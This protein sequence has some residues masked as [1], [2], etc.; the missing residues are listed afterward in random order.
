[1][2]NRPNII[3]IMSDDHAS[4]AI[5]AYTKND[6][7]RPV[8][9]ETPNIDRI[10]REG[11]RFNNCFCTNSICT[12]SRAVILTGKYSHHPLNGVKTFLPM[13]NSLP[14]VAKDLQK[15]GY[16]TAMIGKWHLGIGPKHCPTGFDY[17]K[18][19][20]GQGEYF[21]PLFIEKDIHVPG[22][23]K[24]REKGYVTDLITDYTIDWIKTRDVTKPFFIM[25]HHKAPHRPWVPDE[26][27]KHLYEDIEIP[28]PETFDDD[29]STSAARKNAR[30]RIDDDFNSGDVKVLPPM[31]TG[32]YER[33]RK[34]DESELSNYMLEPYD[35][36]NEDWVGEPVRFASLEERKQYLYQ[37]YIK[38]YLRVIASIDDNIGRLLDFL[39]VECLTED[40]IVIYTSDQG[41]FLGDHG[42]YDKR[43][44]YEESLRM[45][46]LIRYP[47]EIKPGS[48]SDDLILNLDFAE[49]WLDYAGA[50]IPSE[51]QGRSFRPI[52][53][54]E[55]PDDW[56]TAMYY[57]YFMDRDGAHD[58]TAHYGIRTAGPNQ[59]EFKLIYYYADGLGI[60][61]TNKFQGEPRV[62]R[63]R[64]W[65][66]FDL[67]LD[68]YEM[69]NIYHDPRYR[70]KIKELKDI[71]HELQRKFGD[72]PYQP[73]ID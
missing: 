55:T 71:L 54:G 67:S 18:V 50:P 6:P 2:S 37:R 20:P 61:D 1:M 31:G 17:W 16:Q 14:T 24:V 47:R 34:P 3:F 12:P 39:D 23:R 60:K 35:P 7:L 38:D 13:D 45:P 19:L 33:L 15:A 64:E 8:I 68:P 22:G 30:M 62:P 73:E 28:Y 70:E 63:V 42:W 52:L 32:F 46:F 10:A 43:F 59:K 25:C 40:T 56:R 36:L 65:E 41:F 51:M 53:Q 29:Y 48:V 5:S 11:M 72:T 69:N 26:K 27:H 49:T 58:T 4:H 44:M 66:C 21:N 9:N 57:R